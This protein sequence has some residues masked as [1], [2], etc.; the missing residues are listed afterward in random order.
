[1]VGWTINLSLE[2]SARC[3]FYTDHVVSGGQAVY[4]RF[5]QKIYLFGVWVIKTGLIG[6]RT[7]KNRAGEGKTT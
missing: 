6:L 1:M 3:Y 5:K 2:N 4:L 7:I